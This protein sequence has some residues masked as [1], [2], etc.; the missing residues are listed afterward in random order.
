MKMLKIWLRGFETSYMKYKF[1][2]LEIFL[3]NLPIVD[4]GLVTIAEIKHR[5]R[6][7]RSLC[8]IDNLSIGSLANETSSLCESYGMLNYNN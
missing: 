4:F 6:H 8:S 3:K 1:F 2:Q 7:L 5:G